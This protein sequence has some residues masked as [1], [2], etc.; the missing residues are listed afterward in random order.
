MQISVVAAVDVARP[1]DA[2]YDFA[3]ADENLP[4]LLHAF[5]P[6]PGIARIQ[7][8]GG[9]PLEKGARRTVWMTD[10]SEVLEE[11]VAAERG[12]RHCY[13]WLGP[14]AAPFNLL[15]TTAEGDW[16][17][18]PRGAGTRIEWTYTFTLSTPLVYPFAALLM[19][20]F[21]RWMQRGLDRIPEEMARLG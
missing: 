4:R 20:V 9:R 11:I 2:V 3:V 6:I 17:F 15:V 19:T 14:P 1:P 8:Q 13:R 12:R 16:R 7:M 10:R 21:R 5:G 18:T